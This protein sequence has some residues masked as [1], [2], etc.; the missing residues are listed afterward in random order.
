[1]GEDK[2][3]IG[4]TI[5]LMF[6]KSSDN[7]KNQIHPTA[8][9]NNIKLRK[10]VLKEFVIIYGTPKAFKKTGKCVCPPMIKAPY[11]E[12]D[13]HS[14]PNYTYACFRTNKAGR[15]VGVTTKMMSKNK[16]NNLQVH[17]EKFL[18]LYYKRISNSCQL[19]DA[20]SSENKS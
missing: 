3:K 2:Y 9:E 13:P 12:N 17:D 20:F 6:N 5:L 8:I 16:F 15:G 4:S 14:L 10:D 19:Y 1:M 7:N 18:P 11:L